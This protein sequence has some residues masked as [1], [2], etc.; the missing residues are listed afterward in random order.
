MLPEGLRDGMCM[1]APP[2]GDVLLAC[3]DRRHRVALLDHG[4]AAAGRL[5]ALPSVRQRTAEPY[6]RAAQRL[7]RT[8]APAGAIR[9][10]AVTGRV[11]APASG[12]TWPRR[13]G[14]RRIFTGHV[15]SLCALP[16]ADM[17]LTWLPYAQVAACIGDLGVTD[18]G[19]LLQ[20]YVDG[21][22]PDGW[23]TLE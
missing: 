3:F 11:P 1:Y 17:P 6:R 14:E 5:W 16:G 21:W 23:I 8:M 22:I 9:L 4:I 12:A 7:A 10:G 15:T 20:G 18:L 13:Q 2:G 19:L